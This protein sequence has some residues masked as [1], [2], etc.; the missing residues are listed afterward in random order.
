MSEVDSKKRSFEERIERMRE[1]RSP[2]SSIP[3]APAGTLSAEMSS[4]IRDWEILLDE[5]LSAYRAAIGQAVLPAFPSRQPVVVSAES[6]LQQWVASIDQTMLAELGFDRFPLPAGFH[7]PVRFVDSDDAMRGLTALAC[8][9]AG[10]AVNDSQPGVLHLPGQGTVVNRAHYLEGKTVPEAN[11]IQTFARFAADVAGERWG[12]GFLLEY[13][14][15]GQAAGR[16]GLWPALA[17]DRLGLPGPVSGESGKAQALRQ[18]WRLTEAGWQD[19]VWQ[20]VMFKAR[21]PVGAHL[22]NKPRP[23]RMFELVVKILDL[24]PFYVVPFGLKLRLRNLLDLLSFLFLEQG[25][26]IPR[27]LNSVLVFTQGFC[28]EHDQAITG[29]AG[30]RLSQMLGRFYFSQ[31]EATIGIMATPYAALI[32]CHDERLDFRKMK[33]GAALLAQAERDPRANPDTRL[34]LLSNLDPR[35]KY[36]PK[37]MATAAWERLRLE[38]PR[39]YFP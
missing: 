21:H 23:G 3:G 1:K 14:T 20:Y 29:K 31:L 25:E 24:F 8:S 6:P 10:Q 33:D 37:A 27:S 4:R 26:V 30:M 34:A 17:A 38:G 15:L 9:S 32:A 5:R 11:D 12:W 39:G 19:W 7:L 18:V 36:D 2:A 22:F 28:C 35:V 13:T 16:A